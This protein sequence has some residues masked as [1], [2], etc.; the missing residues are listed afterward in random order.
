MGTYL[1]KSFII[2]GL[3]IFK[4]AL[5]IGS[6]QVRHSGLLMTSKAVRFLSTD[7]VQISSTIS[8]EAC[9]VGLHGPVVCGCILHAHKRNICETQTP[10]LLVASLLETS[11]WR[12]N[13]AYA[14]YASLP[15][16][17]LSKMA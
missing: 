4:H 16:Y 1:Y 9:R 5:L 7:G 3:A 6:N 14:N 10:M 13:L 11:V 2:Y 12:Y 15:T 17:T 8:Q